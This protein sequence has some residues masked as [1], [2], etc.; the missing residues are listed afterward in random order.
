[1]W[2]FWDIGGLRFRTWEGIFF[3]GG[4]GFD[5]AFLGGG[6][7]LRG[8]GVFVRGGNFFDGGG[9]GFLIGGEIGVTGGAFFLGSGGGGNFRGTGDDFLLAGGG[10]CFFG[11][12][13]FRG[14]AA[15][16]SSIKELAMSTTMKIL[17]RKCNGRI[18]IVC[19]FLFLKG[20]QSQV[21]FPRMKLS[22]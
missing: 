16:T 18:I 21:S 7:F 11:G 9:F 17:L 14:G 3:T 1:M 13:Y 5:G 10:G 12:G 22:A 8:G 15:S 6:L 4:G 20:E 19:S 2:G